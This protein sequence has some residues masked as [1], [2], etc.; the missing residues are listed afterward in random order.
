LLGKP[1]ERSTVRTLVQAVV[2]NPNLPMILAWR[3]LAPRSTENTKDVGYF[4]SLGILPAG[5]APPR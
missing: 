5:M 1:L 3:Q 4:A 2:T